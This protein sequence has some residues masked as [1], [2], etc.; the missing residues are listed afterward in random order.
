MK[1]NWK[2]YK[3]LHKWPGLVISFILLYYGISGIFMNHRDWFSSI[4]IRRDLLPGTYAYKNWNNA[5]LKGNLVLGPDSILVYGNIGAWLTDSSFSEYRSFNQGFPSGSDNRKLFDVHLT[6]NGELYAASLFGAYAWDRAS[7]SWKNLELEE[8]NQRFQG[9][10]SI[11]DTLYV[12]GRSFLFKGL[13]KG[14]HTRFERMEL[15][16]PDGYKS[17]VG[18][19]ETTWQIH[20]G[21]IFGLPGKLFV[22]LLGL[23][24]IFLS[25]TGILYFFFPGW[26]RSRFRR[27][28]PVRFQV[29]VTRWSLKWHNKIGA[30]TFILLSLLYF[31]GI[32]LRPPLLLTI[33]NSKVTPLRYSHLDQPNPW[34]DK[35]RDVVYDSTGRQFLLS[36]SEGMFRLDPVTLKP[37]WIEY[38]PPVSIMGI[39]SF[40]PAIN[41]AYLVGSFNG[42][43][44]WHPS[45]PQV[46]DYISGQLHQEV[47]GGPPIGEFK[48]T[49]T[50]TTPSGL[51]YGIDY[52]MGVFPL[53]HTSP[54]PGMP[55]N[56]LDA[57]GMSLWSVS[58]ELHTGRFF[59]GILGAFYILIVPLSG[60]AAV[61]VV[62]S[63]YILWRRK[64]RRSN[65]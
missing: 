14:V 6:K 23:V 54:F 1:K 50:L 64:Y 58:L 19:F 11:G 39:N 12:L 36:S 2:L 51:K 21:E 56:V 8:S 42:L 30:W 45:Y 15:L 40:E 46:Y 43:F 62:I 49:G 63:G 5:A 57:S 25:L 48:I 31:T 55:A 26:I 4:D 52:G 60:L 61:T 47:K 9:I 17:R 10:E 38:Q 44:L 33:A 24:T 35:L 41:G 32:F 7:G 27:K 53:H 20:S 18:L 59:E 29:G 28:K 37:H 16:A 34:Y 65:S 22:D 3:K 13:S